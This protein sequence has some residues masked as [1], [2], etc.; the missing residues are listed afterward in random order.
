MA[1]DERGGIAGDGDAL[2]H[3]GIERALREELRLAGALGRRL[4]NF[5][6]RLADDL[7]F[8]LGIGDALEPRQKQL[9]GVHVLQLDVE[10]A[11][12]NL[13]ARPPPRGR[14]AG[15]C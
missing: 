13:A 7:A 5:D 8:A 2:D 9:G 15:R 12:E 4:E 6:E 14:A 11:A 1:L 10:I 3:V